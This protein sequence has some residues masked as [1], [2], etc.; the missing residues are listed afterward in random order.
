[1]T[2]NK[3]LAGLFITGLMLELYFL[4]SMSTPNEFLSEI[5]DNDPTVGIRYRIEPFPELMKVENFSFA[6]WP[7]ES[8]Y[9]LTKKLQLHCPKPSG[10]MDLKQHPKR[11]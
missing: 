5:I 8:F 7:A 2:K 10:C 3:I 9:P 11:R 4:I 1:L 6:Q